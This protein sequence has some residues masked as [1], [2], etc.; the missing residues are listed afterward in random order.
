MG[1]EI[2]EAWKAV[3]KAERK[4]EKAREEYNAALAADDKV[5]RVAFLLFEHSTL[6]EEDWEGPVTWDDWRTLLI[7][8]ERDHWRE[9]A[10]N[11]LEIIEGE[12]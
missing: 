3:V 12:K 10:V 8:E 7:D 2:E 9:V 11:V 5:T 4:L 6:Q 1:I